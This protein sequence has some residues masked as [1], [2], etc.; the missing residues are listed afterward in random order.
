MSGLIRGK[1][2]VWVRDGNWRAESQ[3]GVYFVHYTSNLSPAMWGLRPYDGIGT[4]HGG[5]SDT[6]DIA[7]SACQSDHDQ[8]SIASIE[9][10]P[11]EWKNGVSTVGPFSLRVWHRSALTWRWEVRIEETQLAGD[12]VDDTEQAAITAAEA[13]VRNMIFGIQKGTA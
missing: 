7:Q 13:F 9:V 6:L 5:V 12:V 1:R 10:V 8:R 11:F 2:L 4:I 3:F